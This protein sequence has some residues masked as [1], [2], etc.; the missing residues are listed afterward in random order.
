[1]T[2]ARLTVLGLALALCVS[3]AS[4][5]STPADAGARGEDKIAMDEHDAARAHY[6]KY[7]A[8]LGVG[9]TAITE[10]R[11]LARGG[12]HFFTAPD[13]PGAWVSARGV[14]GLDGSGDWSAFVTAHGDAARVA[15]ALAR[16]MNR[17][18]TVVL[19]PTSPSVA[20]LPPEGRKHVSP[21][22]LTREPDGATTLAFWFGQPPAFGPSRL[23][24][25]I[26]E[27][28]T[29]TVTS[30]DALVSPSD[31]EAVWL[32]HLASDDPQAR[33]LAAIE[34]GK[35]KLARAVP[36]LVALLSDPWADA[37][38]AA[39]AAL[40]QIGDAQAAHG[41]VAALLVEQDAGVGIEIAAALGKLGG[42]ESKQGLLR[43]ATESKVELIRSHAAYWAGQLP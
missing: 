6:V 42:P 11:A 32:R 41:L 37:R 34:V 23:S 26:A 19:D 2:A 33:K 14:L 10:E 4:C 15:E 16:V 35:R 5:T 20:R 8:E 40:V 1:M 7:L 36:G 38:K 9:P 12:F 17:G 3:G 27:G 31:E 21:P 25:R 29:I 18:A 13:A 28:T 43:A 30:L 22:T 39:V 24:A